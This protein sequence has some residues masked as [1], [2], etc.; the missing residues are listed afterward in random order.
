MWFNLLKQPQ[1]GMAN[2]GLVDLSNVPEEE[3]DTPCKRKLEQAINYLKSHASMFKVKAITN[4]GKIQ[5]VKGTYSL[6][7]IPEEVCCGIIELFHKGEYYNEN[8]RKFRNWEY[9]AEYYMDDFV[10]I[11]IYVWDK[12]KEGKTFPQDIWIEF[13]TDYPLISM[14]PYKLDVVT[15]RKL[16]DIVT[17]F[18]NILGHENEFSKEDFYGSWGKEK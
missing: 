8:K 9:Y 10:M 2:V 13:E 4:L 7:D 12:D 14:K 11:N 6:H 16:Y 1:L 17:K 3:E 5:G 15:T 18:L